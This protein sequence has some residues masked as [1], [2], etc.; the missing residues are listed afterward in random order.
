MYRF[1]LLLLLYICT[2]Y[3]T[4]QAQYTLTG[5][6]KNTYLE[7]LRYATLSIKELKLSTSTDAL[8]KYTI[9]LEEGKYDLA[10]T[11]VGYKPQLIT[12]VIRN[13]NAT[14]NIILEPNQARAADVQVIAVRKDKWLDIMKNVLRNKDNY[15]AA[16]STYSCKVYIRAGQESEKTIFKKKKDTDTII[17]NANTPPKPTD[18]SMAEIV[19]QLDK[20][21]NNKIKETRNGI[22]RIGNT[23]D[24]YYQ[25]TTEGDFSLYNNLIK[26]PTLTDI[27]MLSPISAAG[28]NAYNFKTTRIFKRNGR[29][30][31]TISFTPVKAGNALIQGEMLVMDS[32]WVVIGAQYSFPNYLLNNY[33]YFGVEQ[34]YDTTETILP[35]LSRQ[36]FTYV[37]KLGKTTTSGRTLALYTKYVIDPSFSKKYF[38]NELGST[39]LEAYNQ[40]ST[41]WDQVRTE[42]LSAEQLAFIQY[43]DS[44][45]RAHSTQVYIDSVDKA[46]NKVTLSKI[47]FN[48]Q[49]FHSR[50]TNKTISFG[51]LLGFIEPLQFAGTRVKFD[52]S[53]NK[54]YGSQ[55]NETVWGNL[56]YGFKNSD[57]KGEVKVRKLYNTFSRAAYELNVSRQFASL[58]R[59]GSWTD[60]LSRSGIY[61][62]DDIGAQHEIELLNGLYINN[63]VELS[64]RRSASRYKLNQDSIS[65]LGGLIKLSPQ[66]VPIEFPAY[67]GIFNTISLSYTPQQ[68]YLREPREKVILGSKWPTFTATWRK[69]IPANI[70]KAIVDYDYVELG[71]H[72]QVNVALYGVTTYSLKYGNFINK[73]KLLEPDYKF[74]RSRDRLFFLNPATTFQ[75]IQETFPVFNEFYELHYMHNFKGSILNRL[76]F[77]KKLRLQEIVG[78]GYLYVP[79]R[80]LQYYEFFVGIEKVFKLL[81]DR[82]KV[83]GYAVL[84]RANQ[85][86]N[87]LEFKVSFEK[88]NKR[89]NNWY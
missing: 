17:E 77:L 43:N 64:F 70:T 81:R 61:E 39:T 55:K 86:K 85:F 28:L 24:L 22:K 66:D 35:M 53:Y 19:L 82:Y 25:S 41:F 36:E 51:P 18:M 46:Y 71:I 27:P 1:A 13:K 60:Q 32:L 59:G 56:S 79:E 38:S 30:Y 72:Q 45:Q 7:P 83:G 16:T 80:D 76:N 49:G 75:G 52:W 26:I 57:I 73:T 65:Y 69:A 33:D 3:N 68:K 15:T 5:T 78:A 21:P 67:K 11:S 89:I 42:P 47:L 29:R 62:R 44:V 84:S 87:P 8:G 54:L 50:K 74:I 10:I 37:S 14:Q 58:F 63:R 2:A 34:S 6:I 48:G 88:Q 20:G 31:Y 23:T 9:V 4:I 40:D 12:L